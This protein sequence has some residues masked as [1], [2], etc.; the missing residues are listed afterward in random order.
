[1]TK[2]KI[3]LTL[4]GGGARAAYQAGV[5]NGIA[6]VCK[7]KKNPFQIISGISAGAI[8]GMWLAA[9]DDFGAAT[10]EMCN[11]WEKL[12]VDDVYKT[13]SSTLLMTGAKWLRNL[14]L[15]DL[16]GKSRINY[17]LDTS[18]LKKLLA[19]KID[20]KKIQENLDSGELYGLAVS[21]TDYHLASGTTFF[22]GDAEIKE[23]KRTLS[24][25]KRDALTVDHIMASAALPIFFPMVHLHD[26]DYGDGGIG[27]KTPL[28]PAI[29]M[30]ASRI[31]VI[32][33][34]NPGGANSEK[35]TKPIE[36]STL[37]DVTGALLNSIF[38]NSLDTDIARLELLNRTVSILTPEQIKNDVDALRSIPTLV[39]RPSRDLS[40]VGLKEF[41][42][43]PFAIRHLL[44]GLGVDNKK[45]WDLLSYLSFDR[46]YA[47]ALIELGYNDALEKKKEI[48]EF[49]QIES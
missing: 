7:F 43:F 5:L 4:P 23:W 17:L 9:A 18:P 32:G 20:F 21:T 49:F 35:E 25:G 48:K 13:D 29:R 1:M 39:I 15:G 24:C 45:G 3:A 31:L 14:S 19:E 22:S 8:N 10:A 41:A 26:R 12:S 47:A 46:V 28:S 37:G 40:L 34:Q 11:H 42:H 44:R 2:P 38:L 33:V 6:K 16:F 27:L 30:G 36:R